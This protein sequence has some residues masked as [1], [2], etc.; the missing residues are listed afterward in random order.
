VAVEG[1]TVTVRRYRL[2]KYGDRSLVLSFQLG[3]C[4]F[5]PRTTS[6]SD[7][8]STTV[9]ADAELFA[10]PWSGVQAQD[11][12][13]LPDGSHWEVQGRPEEW[14]S[15]FTGAWRPGDVVP[16]KRTTG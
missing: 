6:E 3:Q 2:D 12:V 7:N 15:P 1:I 14:Q 5:A 4:A 11:V 10:P 16:L 9:V 13:Q 8:R